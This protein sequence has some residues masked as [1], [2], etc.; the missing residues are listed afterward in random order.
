MVRDEREKED[1]RRKTREEKGRAKG[2]RAQN[3]I[4]RLCLSRNR[5]ASDH[6]KIMPFE[7]AP[8]RPL[9]ERNSTRRVCQP[10]DDDDETT[11]PDSLARSYRTVQNFRKKADLR[12]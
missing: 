4:C 11:F 8:P 10:H 6:V 12:G 3:P 5:Y 7:S 2:K 1:G 9:V